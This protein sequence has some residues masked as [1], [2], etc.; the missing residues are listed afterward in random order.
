M[1]ASL[2]RDYDRVIFAL[3]VEAGFVLTVLFPAVYPPGLQ[4]KDL[5]GLAV[6]PATSAIIAW[7]RYRNYMLLYIYGLCGAAMT[8]PRFLTD[9]DLRPE[10]DARGINASAMFL[11]GLLGMGFVCCG[12]GY[13]VAKI[14]ESGQRSDA[15][16]AERKT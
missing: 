6:V 7:S 1:L 13:V 3:V 11:V 4:F 10:L 15:N 9:R 8:I 12:V 5:W 16:R 14:A 2:R